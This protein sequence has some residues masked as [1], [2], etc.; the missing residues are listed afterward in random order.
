MLELSRLVAVVGSRHVLTG[1]DVTMRSVRWGGNQPCRARAIVRPANTQEVSAILTLCHATGQTV[2][3][4]GGR[5]GL[6][7]G[8]QAAETDLVISLER[9][10]QIEEIDPAG[11]T[12]LVGAGV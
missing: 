6:A 2:V 3:T 1:D 8:A 5:T 10:N 9:L 4:H 12:A 7:G 11:R